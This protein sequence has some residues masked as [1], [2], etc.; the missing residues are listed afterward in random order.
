MI[1]RIIDPAVW[2]AVP[3]GFWCV[4]FFVFGSV[5]GSFLNVC[6]H[7]MP[8][9][10]SLAFP[11]SYCPHCKHP[12]PW[13]LNI[14]LAS[15]LWLGGRC[16]ECGARI[17]ARY[18]LV[19]LLTA[20]MFLGCWA[21]YG[22]QSLALA[23]IYAG[24]LAGLLAAS[25][26]DLEHIFV[27]DQITLGGMVVGVICSVAAPG[28]HGTTSRAGALAQSLLG[29]G[30]GVGLIYGIIRVGKLALGRYKVALPADTRI[31]FTETGVHW[32]DQQMAYEELFYRQSDEIA[33]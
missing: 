12:I 18:F 25:F 20:A 33:L 7:R 15:W 8:L 13:Y 2:A 10:Q 17:S 11:F 23:L 28:L 5:V 6:I 21:A 14:P 4:V 24:F 29:L 1:S 31:V 26:I 32:K 16:R 22:G 19:E 30:V 9:G 3:F 27:P